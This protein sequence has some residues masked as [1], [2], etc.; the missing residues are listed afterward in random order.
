[1]A[2]KAP[3]RQNWLECIRQLIRVQFDYRLRALVAILQYPIPKIGLTY[4]CSICTV[5]FILVMTNW[6]LQA[7]FVKT[8]E[9]TEIQNKLL[10]NLCPRSSCSTDIWQGLKFVIFAQ[11]EPKQ[12]YWGVQQGE[13]YGISP[14]HCPSL[15][16]PHLTW[17]PPHLAWQVI[18]NVYITSFYAC[19]YAHAQVNLEAIQ[20]EG[21]V[22][23]ETCS[24]VCE[25]SD[26][27]DLKP[28]I[29]RIEG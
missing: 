16:A 9:R 2:I 5:Y 11:F 27:V 3:N 18:R 4:T 14:D 24:D 25:T 13:Y 17:G 21:P 15:R 8:F 26:P 28:D 23:K 22:R 1:M 19:T 7:Q 10:H 6:G 20:K 12:F 29:V